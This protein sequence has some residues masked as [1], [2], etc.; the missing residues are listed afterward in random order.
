MYTRSAKHIYTV[1]LATP[2]VVASK[3]CLAPDFE[4]WLLMPSQ[5]R[6]LRKQTKKMSMWKKKQKHQILHFILLI[7]IKTIQV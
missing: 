3:S 6:Q 2:Q 4:R 1:W 7:L 5:H